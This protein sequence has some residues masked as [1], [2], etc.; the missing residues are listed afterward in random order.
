MKFFV[1]ALA[2]V[3]ASIANAGSMAQCKVAMH[4][5]AKKY[6][7]ITVDFVTKYS[8]LWIRNA[9]KSDQY[10]ADRDTVFSV[11]A[12]QG[13]RILFM[14]GSGKRPNSLCTVQLNDGVEYRCDK[15]DSDLSKDATLI[16]MKD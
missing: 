4:S 9:P 10:T 11:C 12:K 6:P 7:A 14:E 8:G 13:L 16:N 1:L 5:L 15:M 2:L 3:F